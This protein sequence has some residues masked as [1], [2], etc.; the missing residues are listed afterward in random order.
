MEQILYNPLPETW[1]Q[2]TERNV[3]DDAAIAQSVAEIVAA[4]R[5]NGD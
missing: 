3:P 4:V 1:E 2:L 5:R